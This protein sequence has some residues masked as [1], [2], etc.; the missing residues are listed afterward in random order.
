MPAPAPHAVLA[1]PY[2]AGSAKPAPSATCR[3]VP[4]VL[5]PY[6]E[7]LATPGGVAFSSAGFVARMPI[8]MLGLGMVLLLVAHG[9]GYGRAGAISA[10]FAIVNALAAP[11]I[12]RLVDRLGQRRVLLPTVVLHGVW[13]VAFIVLASKEAPMWTLILTVAGAAVFEPSVGSLVRARWGYVLGSGPRLLTAYSFESILDEVIF[14]L[15]PICV[16]VLA[17]QVIEQAGLLASLLLLLV[18]SFALAAQRTTE[19]PVSRRREHGDRSPLSAPGMRVLMT[20]M[21]FLG[22]V[23]GGVE[24]ATIGFA[25]QHGNASLAGPLLACYAG[26]SM[27]AGIVYGAFRWRWSL[28]RRL[29]T[30]ALAM[31]LTISVLPFV[32]R[33]ALLAPCLFVAG[34][35]IAPTLISGFSLVERLVPPGQLTEGLTWATTGI[36]VGIAVA[37]PVAGRLVDEL[38]ARQAFTVGV[39]SGAIAVVIALIGLPRLNVAAADTPR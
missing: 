15:G 11:A 3:T 25:D 23:F 4:H 29:V 21:V 10:V 31:T 2:R 33:P 20:F 27:V 22:G 26:G 9:G 8:S 18:G 35:G 19:P 14:I 17:T 13:L 12:S 24:I 6:R 1:L 36:V 34:L 7:L 28:P 30:G 39:V 38:G 16:A 32:H 37:S 5:R